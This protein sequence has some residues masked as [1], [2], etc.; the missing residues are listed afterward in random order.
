M[1]IVARGMAAQAI[2]ELK[3]FEVTTVETI[4]VHRDTHYDFP[5]IGNVNYLY[6]AD[7]ENISYRWDDKELK[8]FPLTIDYT[9]Q[10]ILIN[11]GNSND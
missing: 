6:I 4:I 11:G 10:Q 2:Q 7:K 9:Q 5:S 3:D 8:F 1:D